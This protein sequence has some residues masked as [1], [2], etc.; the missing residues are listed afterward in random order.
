M[1]RKFVDKRLRAL[2]D[3]FEGF[4]RDL[5]AGFRDL[6]RSQG[7]TRFAASRR[8]L[9]VLAALR[10]RIAVF[11][12]SELRSLY[13]ET[14]REIVRRLR[15]AGTVIDPAYNV[16][17]PIRLGQQMIADVDRAI[18][19]VNRLTQQGLDGD[20]I[21]LLNLS[22]IE[23]LSSEEMR[24]AASK[25]YLAKATK[26]QVTVPVRTGGSRSYGLAYY[27]SMVLASAFGRARVQA[28]LDRAQS[29]EI[30]LVRVS[31]NPSTIGD[32][33]DAYA[34]K[35]FSVGGQT[36]GI[37]LLSETVGGGP[38][39]H[40]NCLHWIIPLPPDYQPREDEIVTPRWLVRGAGDEA[41][42]IKEWGRA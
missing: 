1:A 25:A 6:A 34:G 36:Q 31:S 8:I 15:A 28:G 29:N 30:D 27:L 35:V 20:T 17:S 23:T 32:F 5:V 2:Q 21:T 24:Q 22:Q 39:F 14:D 19:S 16:D 42:I 33:C 26:A 38:P 4:E 13:V 40:V 7:L 37:P 18:A 12:N 11:A 41:R 3:D 9:A 10:S